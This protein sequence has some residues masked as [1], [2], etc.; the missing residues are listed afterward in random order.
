M[1]FHM[2]PS[3]CVYLK[4]FVLVVSPLI[5]CTGRSTLRCES[6]IFFTVSR[7]PLSVHTQHGQRHICLLPRATTRN[8][9]RPST[10]SMP[11]CSTSGAETQSGEIEDSR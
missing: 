5:G 3:L 10:Q 1:L 7:V 4:G 6:S 11:M 8:S 9:K 2:P